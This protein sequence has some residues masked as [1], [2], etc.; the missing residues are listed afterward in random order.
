MVLACPPT[1]YPGLRALDG[2][3]RSTAKTRLVYLPWQPKP[4]A[5][6]VTDRSG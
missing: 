6:A 4:H 2:S 5:T 1:S 3:A